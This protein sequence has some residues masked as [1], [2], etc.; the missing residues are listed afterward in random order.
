MNKHQDRRKPG[1]G[2]V[3]LRI[4]AAIVGGYVFTWGFSALGI[5]GLTGL[6]VDFHESETAIRLLAFLVYLG[7]FLWSFAAASLVRVWAV[8]AGGGAAM[9]LAA[10]ALQRALLS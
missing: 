3:T 5:A 2:E 9:T 10:L 1:W 6:G 7:L 4:A 8:L